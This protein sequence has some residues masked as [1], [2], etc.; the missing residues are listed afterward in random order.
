LEHNEYFSDWQTEAS[1]SKAKP[2]A[3][4]SI[5]GPKPVESAKREHFQKAQQEGRQLP[6]ANHNPD[7]QV[8]LDAIPLG[9]KVGATM[10]MTMFAT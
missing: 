10:I 8:D 5:D 1:R 6:Y 9:A 7:Y 3:A 2:R 4:R